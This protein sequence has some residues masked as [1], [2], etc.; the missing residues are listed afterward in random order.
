MEK[1]VNRFG[2]WMGV[3]AG[4]LL[5]GLMTLIVANIILRQVASP[6]GGMAE[7][8]G[9]VS[10]LCGGFSLLYSQKKKAHIAIDIVTQHI[11]KRPRAALSAVMNLIAVA[12]FAMAAW[13]IAAR[14]M[15]IQKNGG[16]SETLQWAY[17]PLLWVLAICFA[18]FA[19]RV[20]VDVLVRF[21]EAMRV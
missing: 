17:Y 5:V 18:L 4:I 14:A 12:I 7:V 20:L 9:Y 21:R 3:I 2:D 6:F 8:V 19:V 13:Q 11:A 10:A 15:A 16:L 1:L